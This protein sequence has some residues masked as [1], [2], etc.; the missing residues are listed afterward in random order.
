MTVHLPKVLNEHANNTKKKVKFKSHL[1]TFNLFLNEKIKK[2]KP[3]TQM[4]VWYIYEIL[5]L[6]WC[7]TNNVSIYE[8][9]DDENCKK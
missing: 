4:N 5:V 8:Y 6:Q 7:H 9:F 2:N 1:T 3:E